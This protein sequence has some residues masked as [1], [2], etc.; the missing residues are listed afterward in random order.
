MNI[1]MIKR[2]TINNFKQVKNILST[3][4][5][6]DNEID[7]R[8]IKGSIANAKSILG[9]MSLDYSKPV[10]IES[11]SEAALRDVMKT[12]NSTEVCKSN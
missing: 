8:D 5:K 10:T 7:V 3:A 4:S 1:T 2:V 12:L 6:C 9:L 11:E